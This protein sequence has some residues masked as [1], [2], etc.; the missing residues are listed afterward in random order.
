[1]TARMLA[2][3][4]FAILMFALAGS[5]GPGL[6]QEQAPPSPERAERVARDVVDE[7]DLDDPQPEDEQ[8]EPPQTGGALGALGQVLAY[9]FVAAA[10]VG[11]GYAIFAL[12]RGRGG[13]DD[14]DDADGDDTVAVDTG[15]AAAE[16]RIEALSAAQWREQ[17]ATAEAESRFADAVRYLHYAGLLGLDEAGVVPFEPGLPNGAYVAIVADLAR[18]PGSAPEDLRGLNRLMEDATFGHRPMDAGAVAAT[19]AGWERLTAELATVKVA[20]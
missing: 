7:L 4:A 19:R 14:K 20:S 1:M 2:C 6:A 13:G 12:V 17:A 18:S 15:S 16:E 3:L 10:A 8:R 9:L 5:A 11:I